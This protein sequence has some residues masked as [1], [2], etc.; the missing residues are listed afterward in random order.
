MVFVPGTTDSLHPSSSMSFSIFSTCRGSASYQSSSSFHSTTLF[1]MSM[2]LSSVR[3]APNIARIITM[4]F[5]LSVAST[6]LSSH[7]TPSMMKSSPCTATQIF[8]SSWKKVN[9]VASPVT[10]PASS[11]VFVRS[12]AHR[13]CSGGR[14][15]PS[16]GAYRCAFP[17]SMSMTLR[18]FPLLEL[19]AA[20]VS[21]NFTS[22]SGGVAAYWT[23]A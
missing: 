3:S 8:F 5:F 15:S 9:V 4:Y 21:R 23:L 12:A 22:S 13:A 1:R 14:C 6:H 16:I 18:R 7:S 11:I 17:V 20:L 10:N 2:T 19:G